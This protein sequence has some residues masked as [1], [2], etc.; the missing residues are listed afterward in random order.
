MISLCKWEWWIGV[1]KS[2]KLQQL[3]QLLP[4]W[5]VI[6]S[7]I[8][9][10]R[11]GQAGQKERARA[12][13]WGRKWGKRGRSRWRKIRERAMKKG[14]KGENI[15][16]I[17]NLCNFNK[18][19]EYNKTHH[20]LAGILCLKLVFKNFNNIPC[21]GIVLCVSNFWWY[22]SPLCEYQTYANTS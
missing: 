1:E 10:L 20:F 12:R 15:K 22:Y 21:F 6:I 18:A 16:I 9:C 3:V 5:L 2:E 7:R 14:K 8:V 4:V 17:P 11:D 13:A 19:Y